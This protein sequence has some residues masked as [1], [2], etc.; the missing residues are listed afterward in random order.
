MRIAI[1][2]AMA[3]SLWRD[4]AAFALAFILPPIIFIIFA[5]VFSAAASGNLSITLGLVSDPDDEISTQI[6]SGLQTSSLVTDTHTY[7][8][9]EKLRQAI[10]TGNVDAGIQIMRPDKQAVPQFS[11]YYDPMKAGAANLA[12]AALAAQAGLANSNSDEEEEDEFNGVQ[13]A[14]KIIVTNHTTQENAL[15]ETQPIPSMAAYYAAGVGM[16]FLFLSGFQSALSVIEERDAGITER[17]AAG[18]YGLRPMID[19]KFA[20]LTAQGIAQLTLIFLVAAIIFKVSLGQSPI[21]LALTIFLAALSAAGISLGIVGLCRSRSQAHALGAV[22]ALV[23]GALG[24]S[25]APRFLMSPEVRA[26]GQLTPNAW[27][28]DAFSASLWQGGSLDLLLAPWGLLFISAILG[29]SLAHISMKR[30][31][32]G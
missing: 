2:Q 3:L 11:I 17:I 28:I 18:P 1:F 14:E 31:L 24:G 29:I 4:K 19:G 23:M 25:M 20:Y 15:S 13:P 10:R 7:A 8:T 16:L 5:S 9:S 22:L 32:R 26:I 6:V 21:Q 12:E 30:T 27:G